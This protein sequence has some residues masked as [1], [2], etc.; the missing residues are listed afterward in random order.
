MPF[1][2]KVAIVTGGGQGIGAEICRKFIRLG[3]RVILAE[4]NPRSAEVLTRQLADRGD[5]HFFE[6][7]VAHEGQVAELVEKT[8]KLYNRIDALINNAATTAN[9]PLSELS[10]T[11][12]QRVID[13][14]LTG[15]MLCAKHCQEALKV[16]Q[17]SI[18][19]IASTRALMSEPHTEAYSATKGGLVGLTHALAISLGPEIRVNCI[20]P[21]WIETQGVSLA[22]AD[23]EQ[24]PVGRVGQAT[25]IA[26]MVAYLCSDKASFITGQNFVIDGGM[27]RKMIY[28]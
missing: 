21:G 10:L 1:K 5:I 2:D 18:V 28:V 17:G 23:H 6:V 13:V 3:A 11:D 7:D 8:L 9:R 26:E 24:H 25:D 4:I 16:Q 15:P 27:T 20:S 14:N 12:W 22:R 19:N